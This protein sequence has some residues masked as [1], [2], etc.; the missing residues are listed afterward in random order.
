MFPS[1]HETKKDAEGG[2]LH[3]A[4]EQLDPHPGSDVRNG[5]LRRLGQRDITDKHAADEP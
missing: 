3:E 4:R 2:E 5:I 1:V